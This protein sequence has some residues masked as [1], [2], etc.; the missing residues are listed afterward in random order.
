MV[1]ASQMEVEICGSRTGGSGLMFSH[2]PTRGQIK[3]RSHNTSKH[4]GRATS[5]SARSRAAK[6][7]LKELHSNI[8]PSRICV[9]VDMCR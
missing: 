6:T 2:V 4:S 5:C 8:V 3:L 9:S 7:R 1:V